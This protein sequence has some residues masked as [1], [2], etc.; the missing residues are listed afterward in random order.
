MT[1]IQHGNKKTRNKENKK[2]DMQRPIEHKGNKKTKPRYEN[3]KGEP[4]E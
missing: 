1:D 2:N 3:D 4:V